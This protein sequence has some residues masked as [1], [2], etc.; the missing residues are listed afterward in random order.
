MKTR[1][2]KLGRS[3]VLVL[4][5][6]ANDPDLSLFQT[7]ALQPQTR[8]MPA[9]QTPS[10]EIFSDSLKFL[11]IH[12]AHSCMGRLATKRLMILRSL[13]PLTAPRDLSESYFIHESNEDNVAALPD[14]VKGFCVLFDSPVLFH[15]FDTFSSSRA[16]GTTKIPQASVLCVK[17]TVKVGGMCGEKRCTIRYSPV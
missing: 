9:L 6:M 13:D 14:L 5:T 17:E 15:P 12:L 1:Q 4:S 10:V 8:P 11:V 3:D 16:T 2:T 7:S